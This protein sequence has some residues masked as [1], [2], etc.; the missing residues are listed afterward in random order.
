MHFTKDS[1]TS[2]KRC[3]IKERVIYHKR[4]DVINLYIKSRDCL[5]MYP[6]DTQ[7]EMIISTVSINILLFLCF[8]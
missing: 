1:K 6:F 8:Q 4:V 2:Q 3:D 7:F 5:F